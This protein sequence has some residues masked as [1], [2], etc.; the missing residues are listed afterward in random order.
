M[1]QTP[2]RFNLLVPLTTMAL[3]TLVYGFTYLVVL[4]AFSGCGGSVEPETIPHQLP[5]EA[6]FLAVILP[7]MA[8]NTTLMLVLVPFLN[9]CRKHRRRFRRY[10]QV[11]ARLTPAGA[12][13]SC[14]EIGRRTFARPLC[15]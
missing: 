6:T 5:L 1:D 15:G 10:R 4:T 14:G 8:Y 3:G 12:Q 13:R 2:S 9:G 7:S 11:R